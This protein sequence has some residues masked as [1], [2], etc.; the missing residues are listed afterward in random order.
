[1]KF[2]IDENL[3]SE[4]A[5]ALRDLGHEAHTV[6]DENLAGAEDTV[7]IAVA[8]AEE[9]ILLTLD[10]GIANVRQYPAGQHSGVV[11][12]RPVRSGRHSVLAFVRERLPD[13]LQLDLTRRLTIVG[14]TRIRVR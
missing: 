6:F 8:S 1:V 3:P 12:F 9:R 7:V 4:L 10:K 2:K 13:L 5:A 11:L 14:P